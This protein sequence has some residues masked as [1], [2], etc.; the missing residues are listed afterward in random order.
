MIEVIAFAASFLV[1]I[2]SF[3]YFIKKFKKRGFT[4]ID[5]YKKDKRRAAEFG[6]IIILFASLT[7]ISVFSLF[8]RF[9]LEDYAIMFVIILFGLYGLMDD[10][11]R[12]N[13][14]KNLFLPFLKPH[15]P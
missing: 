12:F 15:V 10:L 4:G 5:V 6:G 2:V 8:N 7:T 1:S 13:R 14:A 9:Y 11:A 3:P